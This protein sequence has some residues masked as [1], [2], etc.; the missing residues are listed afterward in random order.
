MRKELLNLLECPYCGG[1]LRVEQNAALQQNDADVLS[2]ILLCDCCAF[3][4]VGG[5]PYL[6]TGR[7]AEKAMRWLGETQPAQALDE[8]LGEPGASE[9]LISKTLTFSEALALLNDSAEAVYLLYRFSDPTFIA[10]ETLLA[11][12]AQEPRGPSNV[13]LDLCGG[14]GHLTRSLSRSSQARVVLADLEF[15]KLYLAKRFIVPECEPVCCNANEPLPFRRE[16]FALVACA[17]AF[18]YIWGKRQ[19]AAEMQR[20]ATA[21]GTVALPHV[22]N[23]LS[24]NPSQGMPLSPSGY[25]RLFHGMEVRTFDDAQ[26]LKA[27]L[28]HTPVDL[29]RNAPAAELE[30][31]PALSLVATRVPGVF[32]TYE[33]WALDADAHCVLNP[34]YQQDS[35]GSP[36]WTRIFPSR[37][38]ED[39]YGAC[40]E[41]LPET[42]ELSVRAGGRPNGISNDKHAELTRRR[43][44]LDLPPNFCS[45]MKA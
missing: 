31:A 22:H 25:A 43:V 14:T 32:R 16:Q 9:K 34:L 41:Y 35:S 11:A 15:W 20:V 38:Y 39:E 27:G 12:L 5:I 42:I 4:I 33:S 18:H 29:T 28:H 2:G 10:S 6:R 36:R 45:Q 21:S 17:D 3:P 37:D 26:F 7:E 44:L 8:L 30:N 19:F 40:K 1:A 13:I 23:A 24:W